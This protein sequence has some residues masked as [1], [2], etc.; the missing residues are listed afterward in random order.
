MTVK[1]SCSGNKCRYDIDYEVKIKVM[2]DVS[3]GARYWAEFEN[4]K[5]VRCAT[6]R[7]RDGEEKDVVETTW[8]GSKYIMTADRKKKTLDVPM[9]SY[10]SIMMYHHEPTNYKKAFSERVGI[11][12]NLQHLGNHQYGVKVPGGI[13]HTYTFE[14]GLCKELYTRHTFGGVR[15]KLDK[16]VP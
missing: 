14:N 13:K 9:V 10:S 4:G 11:Y 3:L 7:V 8:D 6:K 16:I 5:M 1:R 2:V 12:M 15:F